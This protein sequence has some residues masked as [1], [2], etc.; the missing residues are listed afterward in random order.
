[1]QFFNYLLLFPNPLWEP[2]ILLRLA[3]DFTGCALVSIH[4]VISDL[5]DVYVD[6]CVTGAHHRFKQL[7]SDLNNWSH[8]LILFNR[9]KFECIFLNQGNR[10]WNTVPFNKIRES[11]SLIIVVIH[12]Y[13]F[14]YLKYYC[15]VP[16]YKI[17]FSF[18]Y[19]FL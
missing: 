16:M 5:V 3:N 2:F 4:L 7:F 6:Q 19:P 8:H 18:S 9:V 17:K 11:R 1:M 14:S 10:F 13:L 12:Y 15:K